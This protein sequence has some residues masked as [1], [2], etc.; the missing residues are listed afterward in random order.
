MT[1]IKAKSVSWKEQ[2][3]RYKTHKA[4]FVKRGYVKEWPHAHTNNITFIGFYQLF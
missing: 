1:A 2:F 4:L 3:I